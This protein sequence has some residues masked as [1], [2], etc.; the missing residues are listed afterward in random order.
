MHCYC[1]VTQCYFFVGRC[2]VR[3]DK[4][5]ERPPVKRTRGCPDVMTDPNSPPLCW[6]RAPHHQVFAL[7]VIGGDVP[8]SVVLGDHC[9][10]NSPA[11]YVPLVFRHDPSWSAID[12]SNHDWS[13][14]F[15]D[16]CSHPTIIAFL[17]Y[18]SNLPILDVS[19][20]F[21]HVEVRL[22][23]MGRD[24]QRSIVRH[25]LGDVVSHP[26]RPDMLASQ[27]CGRPTKNALARP[28]RHCRSPF[29]AMLHS[30]EIHSCGARESQAPLHVENQLS[31]LRS[32]HEQAKCHQQTRQPR[33]GD[34]VFQALYGIGTTNGSVCEN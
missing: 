33:A 8:T 24:S 27:L 34:G 32:W 29:G 10:Q 6:G 7:H 17:T 20:A 2:T 26:A 21:E 11:R 4:R 18:T 9:L 13:R 16:R 14:R 28:L 3:K 15:I 31:R 1:S 5:W 25:R 19:A 30:P 23:P 22:R 12:Q